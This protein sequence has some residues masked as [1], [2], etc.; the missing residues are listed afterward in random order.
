MQKKYR[1]L[2][3]VIRT[4][5]IICT[6]H[7]YLNLLKFTFRISHIVKFIKIVD[8]LIVSTVDAIGYFS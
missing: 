1:K 3:T 7:V 8:L 2:S 4:E 5:Q 6:K